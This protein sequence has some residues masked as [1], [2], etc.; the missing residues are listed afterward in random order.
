MPAHFVQTEGITGVEAGLIRTGVTAVVV[1]YG[2]PAHATGEH[3]LFFAFVV[4]GILL[5]T[6]PVVLFL[7]DTFLSKPLIAILCLYVI[8]VHFFRRCFAA[9]CGLFSSFG[10]HAWI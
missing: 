9:H 4:V 7:L 2:I 5:E 6:V 1:I 8:A 10:I 3:C